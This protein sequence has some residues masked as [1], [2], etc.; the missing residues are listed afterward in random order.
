MRIPVGMEF[1]TNAP[2][3]CGISEIGYE[4]SNFGKA[5]QGR[6][7]QLQLLSACIV[8]DNAD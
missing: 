1:A 3:F 2:N 8:M 7:L 4:G 6:L 5:T